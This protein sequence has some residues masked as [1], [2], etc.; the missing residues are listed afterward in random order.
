MQN[1]GAA[2]RQLDKTDLKLSTRITPIFVSVDPARDTPAVLKPFVS[3]FY[4]RLVGLTGS[5]SAIAATAKE[6]RVFY[7]RQPATPDGG[8]IVQHSDQAIL[9]GPDGK[10]LAIVPVSESPQAIVATL[11][12]WA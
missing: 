3:A 8:Y 2:M 6:Y 9:F 1:L 7:Q 12:R 4:P 5:A 11:E 10:P